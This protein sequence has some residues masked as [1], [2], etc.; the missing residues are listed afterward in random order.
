MVRLPEVFVECANCGVEHTARFHCEGCDQ[1]V[2]LGCYFDHN[3]DLPPPDFQPDE[4]V[5][6]V[7]EAMVA[8]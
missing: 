5:R 1:E 6:L 4:R 3:G 2:C 8:A 7:P